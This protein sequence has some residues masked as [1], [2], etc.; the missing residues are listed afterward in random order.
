MSRDT[1]QLDASELSGAAIQSLAENLSDSVVAPLLAYAAG[2][3]PAAAAYRA[4]NTADA[5]W[6][7]RT[8]ELLHH[9]RAAAR[10]DDVANLHPRTAHRAAHRGA[11]ARSAARRCG[12][13]CATTGSRPRPTAAGR[14]RRWPAGLGVRLVKR[15]SYA[16]NAEAPAPA[17]ADIGRALES[18]VGSALMVQG[19][20]SHAGKSYLTAALCRLLAD[21]GL[22]V[23]PF[24]AQN[25]SNNAGVTADGRELGRA[26]IVQAA[27]ARIAPEARMNPVLIKP[28]ADTR[29]Q[30]VVLGEADLAISRLPW[31]ER[32]ARLWPVVRESLHGLLDD[33]DV[34]VIEGAGSPAEI[35]LRDGDIVN[36]AVALEVAA[37]VLLCCDIDRG[38]AFAHLLGTWHCL[39]RGG[40]R[41]A[42]GLPAQPL[43]RRRLA[44]RARAR[45]GSRSR[46]ACR[47]SASI[48]WLDVPLP[49]EDG[50]AL[51]GAGR[52]RAA[53]RSSPCPASRTSTS[54]RR[55]ATHARYVRRP[56]RGRRRRQRS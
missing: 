36:M 41:A 28:E 19:C 42:R 5:M 43:P 8:P 14:W 39:R 55:S 54:S 46:R 12:S 44:A 4:L 25:M 40:A 22:R 34:V 13:R 16:F 37:P 29:S 38:G 9:G 1:S 20:T 35:N 49:E 33:Y 30:V 3:L 32:R 50:V 52:R 7:Y 51:Q 47:R 53:S 56:G 31:R 10:A 48:P 17:A 23:A 11:R 21:E 27:A 6:G 24:K 15:G 45:P 18:S 2:G 26:Q